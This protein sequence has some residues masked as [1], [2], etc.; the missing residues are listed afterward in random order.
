MLHASPNHTL[1]LS[2]Q[3]KFACGLQNNI[4]LTVSNDDPLPNLSFCT[5]SD[6]LPTHV[7]LAVVGMVFLSLGT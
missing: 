7:C 4:S 2:F 6:P 3:F 5:L 1:L